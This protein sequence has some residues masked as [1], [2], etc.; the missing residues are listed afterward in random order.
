MEMPFREIRERLLRAGIAPRHVRRYLRE[1]EDHFADLIAEEVRVGRSPEHAK[2]AALMRLG[3]I[4][5]L[6][7]AM[8]E[9]RQFQAWSAK[10]P[11]A[12]FGI[13]PIVL[14]AGAYFLACFILWSGWKMF[15]PGAA[16]PFGG[17]EA[18]SI[19]E[20]QNLY[21]QTGRMIYFGAPLF[22]GWT[23][24]FLAVRQRFRVVWP[25]AGLVL[26]ASFGCLSRVHVIRPAASVAGGHVS[27]GLG[28]G[29][30]VEGSLIYGLAVILLA[31]LPYAIWR[32]QRC[33]PISD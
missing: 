4:E 28:L 32:V 10:A 22:V 18:S 6:A 17:Q 20:L 19:F 23:I 25:A 7:G 30:S 3:S 29:P 5:E 26:V 24:S 16:T 21:F 12:T 9:K 27:M 1:L 33:Q 14:L 31:V 11:W 13:V 2:T 8:L 15:L